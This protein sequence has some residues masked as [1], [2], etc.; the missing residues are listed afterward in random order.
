MRLWI[1]DLCFIPRSAVC[2]QFNLH[3]PMAASTE[4]PQHWSTEF[5][6]V[7]ARVGHGDSVKD[8]S[9][10]ASVAQHGI[11]HPVQ[12]KPANR[13]SY[14]RET[15]QRGLSSAVSEVEGG[16]F[17]R[18]SGLTSLSAKQVTI[19]SSEDQERFP[20]VRAHFSHWSAAAERSWLNSISS[21]H[22]EY[23]SYVPVQAVIWWSS[24]LPCTSPKHFSEEE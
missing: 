3:L 13:H 9:V 17:S 15:K 20:S 21:S 11:L 23:L 2:K 12:L 10:E 14:Q 6:Y 5:C 18:I 8:A 22:G 1:R 24:P 7:Q 19:A 4:R 16:P